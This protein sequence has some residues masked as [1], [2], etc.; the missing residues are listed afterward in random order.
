MFWPSSHV[1]QLLL[2]IAILNGH[3]P[4]D[5]PVSPEPANTATIST[6]AAAVVVVVV[7]VV[8]AVV[9]AVAVAQIGA[10]LS[11]E[12]SRCLEIHQ[13]PVIQRMFCC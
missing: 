13:Q 12:V 3:F 9:V 4:F 7:V 2:L 10:C 5:F 11:Q 6:A 8:V 1:P